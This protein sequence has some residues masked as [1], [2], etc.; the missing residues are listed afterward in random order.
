MAKTYSKNSKAK[1]KFSI[2][3]K[4]A[5]EIYRH[6]VIDSLGIKHT[7]I[8]RFEP[9]N[10]FKPDFVQSVIHEGKTE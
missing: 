3:P 1:K 10:P 7:T 9:Q 6:E 8:I 5:N 2:S 4:G